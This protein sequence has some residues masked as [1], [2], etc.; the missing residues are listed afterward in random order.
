MGTGVSAALKG[1]SRA[2]PST[3]NAHRHQA[4]TA[5]GKDYPRFSWHDGKFLIV[6]DA[7]WQAFYASWIED[8]AGTEYAVLFASIPAVVMDSS[9]N[10]LRDD[11]GIWA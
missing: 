11:S 9:G 8:W 1:Y 3:A 6:P 7:G 2:E 10:V 4:R 5:A